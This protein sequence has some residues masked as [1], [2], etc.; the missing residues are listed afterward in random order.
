SEAGLKYRQPSYWEPEPG[1]EL[2]ASKLP[3]AVRMLVNAGWHIE[4]EGKVFRRPGAARLDV[5]SGVDWVELRAGVECGETSAR[6]RELLEAV[7]R[8]DNMVRLGDGTY[9]LVPEEWMRRIGILAGMGTADDDHIR[10]RRSQA[11]LLDALLASQ[12]EA[13]FDVTF[14]QV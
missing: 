8:G 10:F 5:S 14:A 1:W 13:T 12:P 6:L 2:A 3:R 11:G 9:G 7:R 4:A